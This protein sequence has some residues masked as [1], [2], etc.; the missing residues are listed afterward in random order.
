MLDKTLKVESGID[1]ITALS[2]VQHFNKNK[3]EW[4]KGV[5]S[6]HLV[7]YSVGDLHLAVYE[8][9]TMYVVRKA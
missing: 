2:Y 6:N 5:G 7:I 3:K 8:T 9:E 1:I 4:G